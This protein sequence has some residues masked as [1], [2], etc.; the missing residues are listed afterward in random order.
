MSHKKQFHNGE[1]NADQQPLNIQIV[2]QP[3]D[4]EIRPTEREQGLLRDLLDWQN[5]SAE[6]NW[7]LKG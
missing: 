5:R 7:V 6:A 1:K 2:K 4:A 3:T